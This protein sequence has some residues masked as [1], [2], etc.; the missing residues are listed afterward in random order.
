M[1]VAALVQGEVY[2]RGAALAIADGVGEGIYEREDAG[3][4]RVGVP[5]PAWN[6]GTPLRFYVTP[7]FE[8]LSL[9][10]ISAMQT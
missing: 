3:V 2:G 1:C 9:P 7:I 4:A 8:P 6:M 5:Y 10:I